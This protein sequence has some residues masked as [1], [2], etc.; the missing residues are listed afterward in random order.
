MGRFFYAFS[1]T[2]NSAILS[3]LITA[4]VGTYFI[5]G[6]EAIGVGLLWAFSLPF[7]IIL[8]LLS[9]CFHS[10]YLACE[11]WY[12]RFFIYIACVFFTA[13]TAPILTYGFFGLVGVINR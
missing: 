9:L 12:Q 1:I 2:I 8:S 7:I 6:E 10:K 5:H 13:I 3:L 4:I 11:V